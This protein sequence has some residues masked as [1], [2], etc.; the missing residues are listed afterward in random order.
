MFIWFVFRDSKGNPWQSGL[1]AQNGAQKPAF[2]AFGA[3]ARL[4]DGTCRPRRRAR[5]RG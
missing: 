4:I 2:D 1:Y 3:V 5:G